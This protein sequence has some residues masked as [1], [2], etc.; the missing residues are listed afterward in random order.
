[1]NIE[2]TVKMPKE[3]LDKCVAEANGYEIEQDGEND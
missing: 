3:D 1:M 2:V